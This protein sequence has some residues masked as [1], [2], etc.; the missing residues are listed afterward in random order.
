MGVTGTGKS[1][2]IADC[3][4]KPINDQMI[5][6]GLRSRKLQI[7]RVLLYVTYNLLGTGRVVV[8]T[9]KYNDHTVH[10]I[11]TP[12]FDDTSLSDTDV[13]AAVAQC[14]HETYSVDIRLNGIIYIHRISDPRITG[15]ALKNLE[16]FKKMCGEESLECVVLA[17]TMWDSVSQ[18]VGNV[19]EEELI[20]DPLFWGTMK[21]LGSMVERLSGDKG[22]E[23]RHNSAMN[24]LQ[25]IVLKKQK[26]VLE[27]QKEMVDRQMPLAET[28]AGQEL[29]K[30]LREARLTHERELK[31]IQDSMS[32]A[33]AKTKRLL[34]D[35]EKHYQDKLNRLEKDQEILNM[36]IA[37]MYKQ[38][39]EQLKEIVQMRKD[40]EHKAQQLEARLRNRESELEIQYHDQKQA[41]EKER[42]DMKA[43]TKAQQEDISKHDAEMAG[44]LRRMEKEHDDE[45]ADLR[46]Q[47]QAQAQ[48]SQENNTTEY[49]G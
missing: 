27:I 20:S 25:K 17:T 24:I 35:H 47:S 10:L 3:I 44:K 33:D 49:G 29:D 42:S 34:E 31:M 14:F 5:G 45:L 16:M 40:Q 1:S 38:K 39:E 11:D 13:L 15:N 32:K 18:H 30:G 19:R 6:H 9:F 46:A 12:G 43:S 8:Y 36:S 4:G 23:A 7:N 22:T 41:F 28:S 2:F 37:E 26:I 21:S 48:M